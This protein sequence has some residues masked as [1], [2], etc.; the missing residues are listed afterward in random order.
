MASLT[1]YFN[2]NAYSPTYHLGDRVYGIHEGIPFTGIVYVDGRLHENEDPRVI[3]RLY[4]P[5]KINDQFITMITTT[6]DKIKPLVELD[7][8]GRNKNGRTSLVK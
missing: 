4:L 7:Q 6:H 5:L 1:E 3:V 8:I 2:K